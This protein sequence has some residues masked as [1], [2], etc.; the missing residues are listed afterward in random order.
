MPSTFDSHI[1][2]LQVL[3]FKSTKVNRFMSHTVRFE[4][5]DPP[6][7][8]GIAHYPPGGPLGRLGRGGM[9][10]PGW[11]SPFLGQRGRAV[12]VVREG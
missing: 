8:D 11:G 6:A 10:R 1:H 9:D 3:T 2:L 4:T 7:K 5:S 12:R